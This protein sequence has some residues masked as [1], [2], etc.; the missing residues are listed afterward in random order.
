M[1]EG[2]PMVLTTRDYRDLVEL[3]GIIHET[4]DR[5]VMFKRLC[6]RLQKLVPISSAA[7]APSDTKTRHF[8]ESKLGVLGLTLRQQEIALLAIRGLSNREIAERLFITEQTVKDHLHDVFDRLT[9]KRRSELVA[10]IL[11]LVPER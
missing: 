11:G 7:Y 6:E 5:A 10:T 8:L 9:I 1:V 3:I 4:P 2:S